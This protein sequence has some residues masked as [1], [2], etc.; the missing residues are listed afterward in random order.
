M[1]RCGWLK[2]VV[3]EAVLFSFMYVHVCLPAVQQKICRS[4]GERERGFLL[5]ALSGVYRRVDVLLN[6][7]LGE[8][9]PSHTELSQIDSTHLQVTH[10]TAFA[11]FHGQLRRVTPSLTLRMHSLGQF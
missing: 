3:I 10:K 11:G 7:Y 6:T 2:S 8:G 4:R 1:A 5:S 9:P